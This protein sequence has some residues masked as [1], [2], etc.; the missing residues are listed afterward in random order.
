MD[1]DEPSSGSDGD[2][3]REAALAAA[4][5]ALRARAGGAGAGAG[6]AGA[7]RCAAD[8]RM[9][10]DALV[11]RLKVGAVRSKGPLS[12]S[13]FFFHVSNTILKNHPI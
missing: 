7:A 5:A 13:L 8:A 1:D 4:S 2:W 6:G 11:R 9:R 12:L 10:V 3:S